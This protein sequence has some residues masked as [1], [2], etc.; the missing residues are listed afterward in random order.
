MIDGGLG[1]GFYKPCGLPQGDPWSMLFV[2]LLMNAWVRG[3]RRQGGEPRALADDL[4]VFAYGPKAFSVFVASMEFT[5]VFLHA[6]G[7]IISLPKSYHFASH[8]GLRARLRGMLWQGRFGRDV[9][10]PVV[11]A[12][13]SL[14]A[15][16]DFSKKRTGTT[17]RRRM[18]DALPM[19]AILD[20]LGVP[21]REK[22]M[23]MVSKVH[24]KAFYASEVAPVNEKLLAA[25]LS[26]ASQA[27]LPRS[28]SGAAPALA[29]AS[30]SPKPVLDA[31]VFAL[32]SRLLT[33]RSQLAKHPMGA[34]WAT[35]CMRMYQRMAYPGTEA[36]V[37][38]HDLEVS[39]LPVLQVTGM[40]G[41]PDWKP[42]LRPAGP[43]GHLLLQL[44]SLGA[45]VAA[46]WMV[47]GPM[48]P[49]MHLLKHPRQQ[50][51]PEITKWSQQRLCMET[52]K[53]RKGMCADLAIDWSLSRHAFPSWGEH[54]LLQEHG[55]PRTSLGMLRVLQ[56]GGAWCGKWLHRAG[57]GQV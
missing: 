37:L 32:Q 47:Q 20:R 6:A 22:V 14:G 21:L 23:V 42:P 54:D 48:L 33:L 1:Q 49:A 35:L 4:R 5:H 17:L 15:H 45:M 11:L 9:A 30:S 25:Y 57:S 29:F 31:R 46:D 55:L 27:I 16:S 3:V 7:A 2:T 52:M 24:A 38:E 19:L 43:V 12:A 18:H 13:R 56:S 44:H 41:N 51:V 8:L 40:N 50:L 10:V 39:S 36:H 26:K 34:G 53:R 28:S